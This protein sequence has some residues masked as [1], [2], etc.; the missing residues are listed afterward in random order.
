MSLTVTYK[1]ADIINE[2]ADCVKV[3]KTQGKYLEDD[4]TIDYTGGTAPTLISKSII[5]NG[6]YNAS[7]DN[8]DGYSSVTVNVPGAD[9]NENLNLLSNRQLRY[10][11]VSGSMCLFGSGDNSL[12]RGYSRFISY[13]NAFVQMAPQCAFSYA[14]ATYINQGQIYTV[15]QRSYE[16]CI[17]LKTIIMRQ[18]NKAYI[19]N[20]NTNN[21]SGTPFANGQGTIW[22][23]DKATDDTDFVSWLK[24]KTGWVVY[25]DQIKGFSEAPQYNASTTYI[26]GDVCQYNNKFYGLCYKGAYTYTNEQSVTGHAP[27]GTTDDNEYWEYVADIEVV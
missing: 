2:T 19:Q 6:T 8:A 14:Y 3:M 4:V 16:N 1:G 18:N 22:V 15:G 26:G 9:S 5:A 17:Y 12:Y 25:A 7:S 24:E 11:K 20:Q 10:V 21:F 27:T 13:N 23:Y